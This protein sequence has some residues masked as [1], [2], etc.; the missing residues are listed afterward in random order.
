M[1]SVPGPVSFQFHSSSQLAVGRVQHGGGKLYGN[2]AKA[3]SKDYTG[4]IQ[5]GFFGRRRLD[6]L[7]KGLANRSESTE[8]SLR[9]PVGL[10]RGT[11]GSG[12]T[13]ISLAHAR[14]Q[15]GVGQE[16]EGPL[17]HTYI[18][19]PNTPRSRNASGKQSSSG[20]RSSRVLEVVDTEPIFLRAT[21]NRILAMPDLACLPGRK[22]LTAGKR[23]VSRDND[24]ENVFGTSKRKKQRK[25]SHFTEDTKTTRSG[26][27][28]IASDEASP[29]HS[30][31]P[32]DVDMKP[33]DPRMD[34]YTQ[35]PGH[36]CNSFVAKL[37]NCA[38]SR[39]W[40]ANGTTFPTDSYYTGNDW[41]PLKAPFSLASASHAPM[42]ATRIPSSL[43]PSSDQGSSSDQN[44]PDAHWDDGVSGESTPARNY[45][46]DDPDAPVSKTP[47]RNLHYSEDNLYE[48]KD[49]WHTIGVILGLS[50]MSTTHSRLGSPTSI[51][52]T[53][54]RRRIDTS[55]SNDSGIG[56]CLNKYYVGSSTNASV[57]IVSTYGNYDI[58]PATPAEAQ[59]QAS[60]RSLLDNFEQVQSPFRILLES[61][62]KNSSSSQVNSS[63]S[64]S[65][66][67][68]NA[69]APFKLNL[70]DYNDSDAKLFSSSNCHS[71]SHSELSSQIRRKYRAPSPSPGD[72][73]ML[74]DVQSPFRL[75]LASKNQ[76]NLPAA[77]PSLVENDS[78]LSEDYEDSILDVESGSPGSRFG[79]KLR[80]RVADTEPAVL[81]QFADE[82]Q[83]DNDYHD[84]QQADDSEDDDARDLIASGGLDRRNVDPALLGDQEVDEYVEEDMLARELLASGMLW[85]QHLGPGPGERQNSDGAALTIQRSRTPTDAAHSA[86]GLS[87]VEISGLKEVDVFQGPCLFPEDENDDEEL[88]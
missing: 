53:Q 69:V 3:R 32:D 38:P 46:D 47:P 6:M 84:D 24:E 49:P 60:P 57:D 43:P 81:D 77:Q 80:G 23:R 25:A 68:T 65:P 66:R 62:K 59:L 83:Q 20:S 42:Q 79:L 21:L 75:L 13:T 51:R 4:R 48:H 39:A 36:G 58:S 54:P 82:Q 78:S 28:R 10:G 16:P 12:A 30:P 72:P 87:E 17:V 37:E 15:M 22:A 33:V 26:T 73:F 63:S 14:N 7:S 74:E 64:A 44:L 19:G 35:Q 8:H 88:W 27:R 5:K 11:G 31:E 1:A 85:E 40:R 71:D 61:R 29:L 34:A 86:L 18:P 76:N 67:A 70:T 52:D 56:L 9:S 45:D 2:V 41:P 55:T 50:P